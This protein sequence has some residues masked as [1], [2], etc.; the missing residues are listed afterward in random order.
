MRN[1][2]LTSHFPLISIV[3]FSLS[4]G[5]YT[6]RIISAYLQE[7]GIY[8][9]MTEFFSEQGIV[10]ALVFVAWLIYFMIFAAMKL[11]AD[12]INELSLLFFSKEE[13]GVDIRVIRGGSWIFLVTGILS[14]IAVIDIRAL[15]GIFL[16]A[17]FIYFIFFVYRVSASMSPMGLIGLIMF[18]MI[19]WISFFIAVGYLLLRLYMSVLSS[20]PL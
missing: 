14:L 7:I 1:A 6:E 8:S 17:C 5:I 16:L 12:T 3:L 13:E 9:G 2:Y 4:F 18:H 11:I 20:L 10:F 15:A 19:I